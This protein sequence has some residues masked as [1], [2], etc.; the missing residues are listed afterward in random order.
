MLLLILTAGWDGGLQQ[1]Y[2]VNKLK[3]S[4]VCDLL[5]AV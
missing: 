1:D 5:K 4:K 2:S 3:A